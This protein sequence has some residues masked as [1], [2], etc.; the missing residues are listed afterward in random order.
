MLVYVRWFNEASLPHRPHKMRVVKKMTNFRGEWLGGIV[1]L[2]RIER[3][4]SLYPILGPTVDLS[5]LN[6]GNCVDGFDSFYINPFHS[7]EMYATFA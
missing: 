5:E 3:V 1:P 2:A 4:I 7:H 6:E